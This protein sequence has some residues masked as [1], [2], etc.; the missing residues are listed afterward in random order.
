MNLEKPELN[1]KPSLDDGSMEVDLVL[2]DRGNSL[3]TRF[4]YLGIYILLCMC[5]RVH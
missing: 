3:S 4:A 2:A 5:F 1:R